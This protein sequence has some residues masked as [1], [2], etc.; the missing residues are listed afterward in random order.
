MKRLV[1]HRFGSQVAL[2][3]TILRRAKPERD[4]HHATEPSALD[5]RLGGRVRTVRST[6]PRRSAAQ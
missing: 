1:S 6:Q 3:A 5:V 2:A 4:A